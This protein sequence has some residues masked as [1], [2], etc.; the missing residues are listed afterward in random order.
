MSTTPGHTTENQ[1]IDLSQISKKI[2]KGFQNLGGFIFNCIHF[3]IKNAVI[4]ILLFIIGAGLGFYLDKTQ[5][6]YNHEIIV[7]PNFGS[8]DY[9]YGKVE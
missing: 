2:S 9:L 3:F 8:T 1:E 4:V 7:I 5:K 6:S